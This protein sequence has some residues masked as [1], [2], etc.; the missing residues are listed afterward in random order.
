MYRETSLCVHWFFFFFKIS[1][2]LRG[3]EGERERNINAWLPLEHPLLGIWPA[4]EACALTGN[5]I[6]DPVVRFTGWHSV[7]WG[8]PARAHWLILICALTRH[9]GMMLCPT[10]LPSLGLTHFLERDPYVFLD[11]LAN[12]EWYL[13]DY[14]CVPCTVLRS[15]CL[16]P[17]V[18]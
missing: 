13:I 12:L 16:E 9:I 2:I 10:E 1:F 7:H 6:S 4:T 14:S 15:F 8:T 11:I 5:R 17:A 3:K 18:E